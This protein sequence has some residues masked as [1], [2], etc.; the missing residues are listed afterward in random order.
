M[1]ILVISQVVLSIQDI[2][3][4]IKILILILH[5]CLLP[6][7]YL[8]CRLQQFRNVQLQPYKLVQWCQRTTI[9]T[10]FYMKPF[11]S[12]V[13]LAIK[14]VI[15]AQDLLLTLNLQ[16]NIFAHLAKQIITIS[17]IKTKTMGNVDVFLDSKMILIR[18][19]LV[20]L[21]SLIV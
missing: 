18:L 13:L 15:H 20:Y 8:V 17:R 19:G 5:L 14:H 3:L 16:A 10:N 7:L 6:S 11:L 9:L 2:T 4:V 1:D 21:V 12:N